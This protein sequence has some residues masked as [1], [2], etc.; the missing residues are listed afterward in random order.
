MCVGGV[1]RA[2]WWWM[3]GGGYVSPLPQHHA[4]AAAAPASW[5]SAQS[6]LNEVPIADQE[7][8]PAK[9]SLPASQANSGSFACCHGLACSGG[10]SG[11]RHAPR[12]G[13]ALW[14]YRRTFVLLMMSLCP[15]PSVGAKPEA[16]DKLIRVL[17]LRPDQQNGENGTRVRVAPTCS[18]CCCC[19]CCCCALARPARRCSCEC[20]TP[21][22]P[23]QHHRR[24]ASPPR[25][26]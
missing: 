16:S 6:S 2:G 18:C 21:R 3:D 19:C 17:L 9:A 20:A 22:C 14:R 25:S 11:V 10:G 4:A 24:A 7:C 26:R 1:C 23:R 8:N 13:T 15:P 5:P 12:S